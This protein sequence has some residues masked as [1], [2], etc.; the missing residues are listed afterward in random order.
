MEP[1]QT[2]KKQKGNKKLF[3]NYLYL[4]TIGLSMIS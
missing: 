4:L 1:N 3:F 2:N